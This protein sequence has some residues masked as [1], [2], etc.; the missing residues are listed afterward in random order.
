M[1]DPVAMDMVS[2]LGAAP[3]PIAWG[4]LYSAL[5]QG[6]VD[7]GAAHATGFG[8]GE[9]KK[10]KGEEKESHAGG[11]GTPAEAGE[12]VGDD[13]AGGDKQQAGV[14]LHKG[15][16]GNNVVNVIL[17]DFRGFDTLGEIVVLGLAAM[18]V[19]TLLD[20]RKRAELR[21]ESVAKL[22]PPRHRPEQGGPS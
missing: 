2:A 7:R 11:Y 20:R 12:P 5:Q 15:G 18:G 21:Q 1:N 3:T 19:W 8:V 22:P 10:H 17:V 14:V 6:V 9:H 13:S 16:G 4:E